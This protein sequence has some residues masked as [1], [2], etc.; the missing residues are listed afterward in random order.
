M[1][2][3]KTKTK[4]KTRTRTKTKTRT[5]TRTKTKTMTRTKTKTKTMIEKGEGRWLGGLLQPFEHHS[6]LGGE[7]LAHH[8]DR[9][10]VAID[11]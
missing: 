3:T 7:A 9:G 6:R 1:T 8:A 5:K 11:E 10:L 4:T 2:R